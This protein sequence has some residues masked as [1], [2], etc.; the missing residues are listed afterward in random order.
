MYKINTGAHTFEVEMD[1][2]GS[3]GKVNQEDFTV[4]CLQGNNA[5]V[6][7]YY[8]GL[9]IY[10]ISD[11]YNLIEIGSFGLPQDKSITTVDVQGD[12]AYIGGHMD[13]LF[14][15]DISDPSNPYEA[16]AYEEFHSIYNLKVMH[17][18]AYLSVEKNGLSIIDIAQPNMASLVGYSF[19]GSNLL[20]S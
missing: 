14:I 1:K 2:K 18:L 15:I 8:Y 13:G 4:I 20:T 10:D 3:T 12:Y 5:Y 9:R 16:G 11:P 17:N 19:F 7:S 6:C